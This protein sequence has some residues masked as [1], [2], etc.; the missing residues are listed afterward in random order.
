MWGARESLVKTAVHLHIFMKK[1]SENGAE[2]K[3]ERVGEGEGEKIPR[4]CQTILQI[5]ST[6]RTL[7]FNRFNEICSGWNVLSLDTDKTLQVDLSLVNLYLGDEF[8]VW[9]PASKLGSRSFSDPSR[10]I[11]NLSGLKATISV[12]QTNPIK[13]DHKNIV[14]SLMRPKNCSIQR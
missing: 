14:L 6:S 10:E 13:Y 3:K 5:K 11:Q 9:M 4:D 1:P 7:L 8:Y 12:N 2:R